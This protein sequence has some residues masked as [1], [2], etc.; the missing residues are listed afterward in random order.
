MQGSG[1]DVEGLRPARRFRHALRHNETG[2]ER[3]GRD[4]QYRDRQ[5]E[6]IG[7]DACQQRGAARSIFMTTVVDQDSRWLTPSNALANSYESIDDHEQEELRQVLAQAEAYRLRCGGVRDAV[8]DVDVP[9]L[10]FRLPWLDPVV[11][12]GFRMRLP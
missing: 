3:E 4:R 9:L 8:L 11:P 10:L 6:C 12:A 5:V 2:S 7:R 1:R